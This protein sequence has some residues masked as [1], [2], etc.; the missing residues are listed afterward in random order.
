MR[1]MRGR[2][3]VGGLYGDDGDDKGSLINV[4]RCLG[5]CVVCAAAIEARDGLVPVYTAASNGD[6]AAFRS[7]RS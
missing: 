4:V 5:G 1:D 7:D 3:M 6:F 2:D